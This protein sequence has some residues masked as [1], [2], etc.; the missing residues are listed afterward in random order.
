MDISTVNAL[1]AMGVALI[2]GLF[3]YLGTLHTGK[4]QHSLTMSAV[5]TKIALIQR[6]IAELD[7]KQAIHNS[8]IER[9]YNVEK[10]ITLMEEKQAVANHRIDDLELREIN[11]HNGQSS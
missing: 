6:D 9:M 1:S 7:R 11:S 3:S 5:E 2:T 4:R 8:V 10:A